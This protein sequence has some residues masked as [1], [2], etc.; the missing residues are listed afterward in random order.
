M[1]LRHKKEVWF[2]EVDKVNILHILS[3]DDI[4]GSAKCFLELLN[5]EIKNTDIK[6]VVI[7]PRYNK[8]TNTSHMNKCRKALF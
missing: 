4:Y 7:T 6:P 3:G 2:Q 5:R 8:I 1:S